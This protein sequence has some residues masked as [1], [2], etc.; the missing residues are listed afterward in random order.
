M[1]QCP[2]CSRTMIDFIGKRG[3]RVFYCVEC[4]TRYDRYGFQGP[5]CVKEI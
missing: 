2:E 4:K 3:D 5:Y 1:G